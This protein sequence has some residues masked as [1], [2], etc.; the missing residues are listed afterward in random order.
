MHISSHEPPAG[1][2][3]LRL[4]IRF[5]GVSVGAAIRSLTI[6]CGVDSLGKKYGL[7]SAGSFPPW[8]G[9]EMAVPTNSSSKRLSDT[10]LALNIVPWAADGLRSDCDRDLAAEMK[11]ICAAVARADSTNAVV[12]KCRRIQVKMTNVVGALGGFLDGL[13][14]RFWRRATCQLRCLAGIRS[15]ARSSSNH[16]RW[17]DY[18]ARGNSAAREF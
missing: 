9:S 15:S 6:D 1:I 5:D 8:A 18:P 10:T 3:R 14:L 13:S 16:E 11:A 7:R 12:E 4:L 17:R 2:D